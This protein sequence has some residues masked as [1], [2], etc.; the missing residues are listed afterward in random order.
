M[1]RN[2]ITV[3][4]EL[5][6]EISGFEIAK[7]LSNTLHNQSTNEQR[8][9]GFIYQ[10]IKREL[11]NIPFGVHV[12]NVDHFVLSHGRELEP[13]M[14]LPKKRIKFELKFYVFKKS[15]LSLLEGWKE[16]N[17]ILE[18]VP[19]LPETF[20]KEVTFEIIISEPTSELQKG[21]RKIPLD[22]LDIPEVKTVLTVFLEQFQETEALDFQI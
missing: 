1:D 19:V 6:A 8:W 14:F 21:W 3:K 13:S 7:K 10:T 11:V 9:A 2:K 18:I 16:K 15:F 17:F 5:P 22:K 20:Y 4:V 12:S